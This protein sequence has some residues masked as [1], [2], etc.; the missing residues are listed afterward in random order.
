MR[1]QTWASRLFRAYLRLRT[2]VF[3]R[4]RGIEVGRGAII[5]PGARVARF[6]GGRIRIGA[7][8]QIHPGAML[9]TYG[10]EI[11]LGERCSVNPYAVLYGHGGLRIGNKVRIAAHCVIIPA[12]HEIKMGAEIADQK[13]TKEGVRI[14]DGVWLGAHVCVL[15]GSRL[16]AGCVVAAGGVVRGALMNNGIYGGVP[17]RLLK[18][19]SA[20]PA[21]LAD[22][23]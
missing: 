17:V 8:T 6:G 20:D 2:R 15:D 9:L 5:W 12:N 10:G 16:G 19:R 22:A 21:A 4:V 7:G 13:L 1:Q 18:M 23:E 11:V 14:E 3:A